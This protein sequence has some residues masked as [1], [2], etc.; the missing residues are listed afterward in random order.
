MKYFIQ[1]KLRRMKPWVSVLGRLLVVV[2]L[3][4]LPSRVLGQEVLPRVKVDFRD[5]VLEVAFQQSVITSL[6]ENPSSLLDG[7]EFV[8]TS[9]DDFENWSTLSVASLNG[10]HCIPHGIG[11]GRNCGDM[12]LAHMT[13]PQ[14]WSSAVRGTFEFDLLLQETPS[15]FISDSAK[16]FLRSDKVKSA[17]VESNSY[18]FPWPSGETWVV[19]NNG[20]HEGNALD[21][22]TTRSDKRVLA[23]EEGKVIFEC[24]GKLTYNIKIKHPND[25]LE[26][27]HLDKDKLSS[28]KDLSDTD[29]EQGTV[30]GEL[31]SGTFPH[32]GCGYAKQT[33]AHLHWVIPRESAFEVQGWNVL[34]NST[35][36]NVWE[37]DGRRSP[38]LTSTNDPKDYEEK[39]RRCPTP[40]LDEPDSGDVFKVSDGEIEFDWKG[41]DSDDCDLDNFEL[42]IKDVSNMSKHGVKIYDEELDDDK[43]TLK[44]GSDIPLSW[45]GK[46]LYWSVQAEGDE[47]DD[48]EWASA[49]KFRIEENK[50]K[51]IIDFLKANGST[52]E[53]IISNQTSWTFTGTASDEDGDLDRV[54]FKCAGGCGPSNKIATLSGNTWTYTVDNLIGKQ[55]VS[56]VAYD[57]KDNDTVSS[58]VVLLI[59]RAHPVSTVNV[60]NQ[61]PS[62]GWYGTNVNVKLS[63]TDQASGKAI[64]GIREIRYR[65]DDGAEQVYNG[66]FPISGDGNH[67]IRYYAVDKVGNQEAERTTTVKIDQTVPAAPSGTSA[68]NGVPNNQWQKVSKELKVTWPAASDGTGSGV[69]RYELQ[70]KDEAGRVLQ[71]V[72][73]QPTDRQFSSN[74]LRTGTYTLQGRT[75]DK[76]GNHSGW[77]TMY[78]MKYD[79]TAPNN[80]REAT[81]SN[82]IP[83]EGWQKL[84]R[85]A[86]FSWL[87]SAD[88]GSGIEEYQVYWGTDRSGESTQTTSTNSFQSTTQICNANEACT[89]Y[90][91]IKAKDK[92]GN[93]AQGWST[94]FTIR[95]D[96]VSPAMSISFPGNITQTAQSL[97]QIKLDATDLIN[98]VQGSGLQA[99]RF[100]NNGSDWSNWEAFAEERN[101]AIP[102][103][104]GQ[105]S[106]IY[107]QVR[108]VVGNESVVAQA[109]IY[110][111]ANRAQ[112]KSANYRLFDY[113]M[114]AGGNAHQSSSYKGQGTVGQVMDS[115]ISTSANY[116]LIGGYQAGSQAIPIAIPGTN[117][118]QA[119][120]TP[121]VQQPGPTPEPTPTPDCEFP[122]VSINDSDLFT[123]LT[124]V[125][126]SLCAPYATEMKISNDGGF[127]ST[128]WEPYERTKPWTIETLGVHVLPR[129]VYVAFRDADGVIYDVY[130]DDI[131]FDPNVPEGEL[132][133]DD[134]ADLAEAQ[135]AVAQVVQAAG[136]N[137]VSQMV[138]V[139]GRTY[140]GQSAPSGQ[141]L[142]PVKSLNSDGMV[143]LFLYAQ[144]DNSGITHM[145]VMSDTANLTTT[146]WIPF[147]STIMWEPTEGDGTQNVYARFQDAAGNVSEV[148]NGA[149][150][151]DTEA[152]TGGLLIQSD[153]SLADLETIGLLELPAIVGADTPTVT[154]MLDAEDALS[155]VADVRIGL[156]STLTDAIWQ[157]YVPEITW[158]IYITDTIQEGRI[159]AQYRDA[160]S[161]ESEVY[162]H[163]YLVDRN[164]PIVYLEVEDGES[165]TRE[166]DILAYDELSYLDTL[167]ISNDSQMLD[168]VVTQAF[169]DTITWTFDERRVIWIQVEDSNG[170]RSE[171]VP[172][173]A[174][175]VEPAFATIDGI[176][177]GAAGSQF[178][179]TGSNLPSSQDLTIY[180][181]G[182]T[183]GAVQTDADGNISFVLTTDGLPDGLYTVTI[184]GVAV[185][186]L[187]EIAANEAI[188]LSE[189]AGP[190]IAIPIPEEPSG[191]QIYMPL[192][193]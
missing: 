182:A 149:F 102:T 94:A 46:D 136:T 89:G 183:V 120:P 142:L 116:R 48:S 75:R 47:S 63:A 105:S 3:L 16:S 14:Q 139:A 190:I 181:D 50:K 154:L 118:G 99:M 132:L 134:P 156:T 88:L 135:Q 32:D 95:Y 83:N 192:I 150:V 35:G 174:A 178:D 70:W 74:P 165:L 172:A 145:Q 17:T 146:A 152:P 28:F 169:T 52:Q 104:S 42:R 97:V 36:T 7:S 11:E 72:T 61:T 62:A 147:S 6:T 56:F 103:I 44:I 173:Y 107:A 191:Y 19:V 133:T 5:H 117:S 159:Y 38:Y 184:D 106:T 77:V 21:F 162:E 18:K 68:T 161:N 144:D 41:F 131:I 126:L 84:T 54:E 176:T 85:E 25:T 127:D 188:Q 168:D 2:G 49:R 186:V 24:E 27:F 71:Q 81:H 91:R 125:T 66:G 180:V 90:L 175:S 115:N 33:Y 153:D 80:P 185:P 73:R 78:T 93:F 122:T 22:S 160:Q 151:V 129:W 177:S 12:I 164:E 110:F 138:E 119:T 112:P 157:P 8:I 64:A 140:M 158:P 60:N 163:F 113:A 23:A 34:P 124:D 193:E 170:N 141:Q 189:G 109:N 15:K 79:G 4:G 20:W 43:E 108:D 96:G 13:S 82:G 30:L 179:I 111:D 100:S 40:D 123:N 51:P 53:E 128:S 148:V 130:L 69:S 98:G 114:S 86:D 143:E 57:S 187:I 55:T 58:P 45:V 167:Y 155:G 29:V 10:P 137:G 31:I 87:D 101:W 92:V 166:V 37:K 1:T 65:L 67:T 39:S 76:V 9:R 26:Y 171:P 121:P 59:D